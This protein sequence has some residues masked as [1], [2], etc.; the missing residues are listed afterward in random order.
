MEDEESVENI[1]KEGLRLIYLQKEEDERQVA[2]STSWSYL[3]KKIDLEGYPPVAQAAIDMDYDGKSEIVYK[4]S[5]KGSEKSECNTAPAYIV[6]DKLE[7]ER[8]YQLKGYRFIYRNFIRDLF[9]FDGRIHTRSYYS[10]SEVKPY[11]FFVG[12]IGKN[13]KLCTIKTISNGDK[14]NVV[15]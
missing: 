9:Y 7:S 11:N 3:K 5:W 14:E 1:L 10:Y 8:D 6:F 2:V 13:Y 4:V 12:E 15:K